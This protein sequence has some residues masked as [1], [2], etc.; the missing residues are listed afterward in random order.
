MKTFQYAT[1][2]TILCQIY[3]NPLKTFHNGF[4]ITLLFLSFDVFQQ[5]NFFELQ[6]LFNNCK[7]SKTGNPLTGSTDKFVYTFPHRNNHRQLIRQKLNLPS[8]LDPLL[9]RTSRQSIPSI[10][11][12]S[13][14]TLRNKHAINRMLSGDKIQPYPDDVPH[15]LT[16]VDISDGGVVF[17][18]SYKKLVVDLDYLSCH[19]SLSTVDQQKYQS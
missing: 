2:G 13:I 18:C 9:K 6:K 7:K 12:I 16:V 10:F 17:G 15:I 4:V 8:S 1:I 14:I 5:N 19:F 3:K 11:R